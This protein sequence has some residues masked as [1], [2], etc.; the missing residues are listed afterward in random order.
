MSRTSVDDLRTQ[1]TAERDEL[2]ARLDGRAL[3][4]P[5]SVTSRLLRRQAELRMDAV[6]AELAATEG[7]RFE[8]ALVDTQAP[9]AHNV[10]TTVLANLLSR[11]QR[12]V[13]YA[14]WARLSG[15][16]VVGVPPSLVSRLFETQ[17]NAFAPGS[18]VVNLS[19]HEASLEHEALDGAIDAFLEV[20]HAGVEADLESAS[21]ALS[22]LTQELGKEATTRMALFF[23]KLH[24]A[25]MEARFTW[26]NH[27]ERSVSVNPEQSK[28]LAE[29]LKSVEQEFVTVPLRGTLT[30]ADTQAGRFAITD[31]L[32]EVHE[33]RA[34]PELLSRA[35]IDAPYRAQVRVTRSKSAATGHISERI[36]LESLAAIESEDE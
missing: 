28:M 36:V 18:F 26:A 11:F 7:E 27:P 33:G 35:V 16:G 23:A 3:A 25:Q 13:T 4:H 12:A 6:S 31:E 32:G 10:S 20:A 22:P 1:L 21:G 24:E 15:P 17:V 34:A 2:A 9:Q 29:W 30:A 14:G 8:M 5:E 19:P